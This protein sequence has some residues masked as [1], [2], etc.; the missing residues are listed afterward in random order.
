MKCDGVGAAHAWGN[1]HTDEENSAFWVFG[2][3][4]VDDRLQVV[5]GGGDGDAAEAVV[6]AKFEDEDVC[7][8][9]EYPADAA[10]AAGGGFTADTGVYDFIGLLE[11]VEAA[12]DAGGEGFLGAESIAGGEAV[13]EEDDGSAVIFCHRLGRC[14]SLSAVG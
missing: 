1:A 9:S 12:A 3:Y 13:A 11:G 7:G 14:G 6:G 4:C 8:L 5:T 10:F 2:S